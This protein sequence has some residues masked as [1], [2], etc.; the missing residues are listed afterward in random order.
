MRNEH[1]EL[2]KGCLTNQRRGP[3]P[4]IPIR[5]IFECPCANCLVKSMC[6]KACEDLRFYEGLNNVRKQ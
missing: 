3:C 5:G 2:C 6:W 4:M 1:R